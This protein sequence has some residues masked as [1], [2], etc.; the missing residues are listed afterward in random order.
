MVGG[1]VGGEVKYEGSEGQTCLWGRG[2]AREGKAAR[3]TEKF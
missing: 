3:T 1:K 2:M